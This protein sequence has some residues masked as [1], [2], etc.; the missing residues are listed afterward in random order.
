M[1]NALLMASGGIEIGDCTMIAAHA[2]LIY[3]M[4]M[5]YMIEV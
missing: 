3:Q 5:I 1:N 4:I 2:K